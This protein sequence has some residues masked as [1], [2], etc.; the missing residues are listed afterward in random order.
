MQATT[1]SDACMNRLTTQDRARI[2]TVLSEGM[3]I[4]V[5]CRVTRTS[6][7]T[8]LKLLADVGQACALYQDRAKP[9]ADLVPEKQDKRTVVLLDVADFR[10]WPTGTIEEAGALIGLKPAELYDARPDGAE[11]RPESAALF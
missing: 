3:G 6:K 10:T 4:N 5:A 7:N 11:V 1:K 8:I 9:E 2:L